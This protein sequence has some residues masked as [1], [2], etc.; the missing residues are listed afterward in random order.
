MT[1]EHSMPVSLSSTLITIIIIIILFELS[2]V[3]YGIIRG[4]VKRLLSSPDENPEG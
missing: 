2:V 1:T 3:C 4:I